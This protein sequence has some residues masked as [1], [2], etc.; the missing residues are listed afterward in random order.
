MHRL[1]LAAAAALLLLAGTAAAAP[2]GGKKILVCGARQQGVGGTM[3]N[4]LDTAKGVQRAVSRNL[5]GT[6]CRQLSEGV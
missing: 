5:A 4:V 2:G 3:A 6:D 1:S